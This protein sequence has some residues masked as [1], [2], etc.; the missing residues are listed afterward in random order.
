MDIKAWDSRTDHSDTV[1][2]GYNW[3]P[4]NIQALGR[5]LDAST[6]CNRDTALGDFGGGLAEDLVSQ[7][8]YQLFEELTTLSGVVDPNVLL[9]YAGGE[10]LLRS[11]PRVVY[12]VQPFPWKKGQIPQPFVDFDSGDIVQF[13]AI[14]PPRIAINQQKVRVFGMQV[15]ITDEGNEKLGQLALTPEGA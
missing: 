6:M 10:V 8:N 15:N 9:A 12:A 14:K 1:V 5:T 13:S 11:T 2:F 4:N 7:S 3:G